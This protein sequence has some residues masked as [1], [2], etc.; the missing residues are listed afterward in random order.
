M[1]CAARLPVFGL[2][3]AAGSSKKLR[4]IRGEHAA[5]QHRERRSRAALGR[6]PRRT[7]LGL[8]GV[9]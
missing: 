7:F 1:A 5:P 3:D 8:G 6:P 2:A 4:G 9:H